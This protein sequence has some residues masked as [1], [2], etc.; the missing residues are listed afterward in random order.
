MSTAKMS[1]S[2]MICTAFGTLAALFLFSSSVVLADV[3]VL[4][5]DN[6]EKEV[7]QDRAALVE[8]YAPWYNNLII[9]SYT[10]FISIEFVV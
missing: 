8:F 6:F 1:S 2:S 4:T 9:K 5:Q 7:G 10:V 3:V